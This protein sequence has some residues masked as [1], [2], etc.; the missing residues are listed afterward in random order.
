[1]KHPKTTIGGVLLVVGSLASFVGPWLATGQTPT[2]DAWT[3]LF[4]GL[5]AGVVAILA[6]DGNNRPA[7][8]DPDATP[9]LGTNL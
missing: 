5:N 9:P 7:P 8:V 2:G 3:L 6:A 1:M 4:T